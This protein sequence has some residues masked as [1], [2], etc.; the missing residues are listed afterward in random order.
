[1]L[2]KTVEIINNSSGSA[3]YS[4]DGVWFKVGGLGTTVVDIPSSL[5][6]TIHSNIL[7]VYPYLAISITAEDHK[8]QISNQTIIRFGGPL[9]STDI[10]SDGTVVS[11]GEATCWNDIT[12]SLIASQLNSTAGKLDYNWDENSITMQPGGNIGNPAD[13]LMFCFQVPHGAKLSEM[14]LHIHWE[15]YNTAVRTFRLDYRIQNNGLAK[16]TIW[17]SVTRSTGSGYEAFQYISGVLNQ[18]T[19]L[20]E[21]DLSNAD[22]SSTVQFRLTRTDATT[23]DIESTFV[24]AHIELD[25]AGSQT[26]YSKD[27]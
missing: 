1:M 2:V 14:R 11:R 4:G 10:L 9:G 15:Q 5:Y 26:E 20:A 6:S 8:R 16:N 27:V 13:R 3:E 18:I 12:G 21:I 25:T 24:D 22:L 19:R 7:A 23:G 17:S